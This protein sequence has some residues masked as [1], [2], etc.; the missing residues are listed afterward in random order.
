MRVLRVFVIFFLLSII[1]SCLPRLWVIYQSHPFIYTS[2]KELAQHDIAI[3]FGA[4]FESLG[5]PSVYV[6]DRVNAAAKLYQMQKIKHLLLSGDNRFVEFNEPK[7]MAVLAK[8]NGVLD[9]DMVIDYAGRS[10]YETCYR[11]KHIF[12]VEKAVLVTQRFHL[13]RAIYL[14]RAMGVE[15]VGFVAD[16]LVSE[17]KNLKW[18]YIREIPAALK[19]FWELYVSKPLPVLGEKTPFL[20]SLDSQPSSSLRPKNKK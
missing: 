8:N 1:L 10:S 14:C 12:G 9:K 4:G 11:A 3:V 20:K 16:D 18:N 17:Y 7:A 5:K 2:P 6:Q 19:A 13:D 15:A